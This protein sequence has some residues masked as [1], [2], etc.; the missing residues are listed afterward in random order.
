M[1]EEVPGNGVRITNREIYDRLVS[2]EVKVD[3]LAGLADLSIP[4]SLKVH[5]DYESRLRSLEKWRYGIPAGILIGIFALVE[6][7]VR[8]FS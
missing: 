3:R 1:T 5:N 8:R 7:L 4:E 2:L 6:A